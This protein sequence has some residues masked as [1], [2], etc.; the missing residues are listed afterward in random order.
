MKQILFFQ[1]GKIHYILFLNPNELPSSQ[2]YYDLMMADTNLNY[3][4]RKD[5]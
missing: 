3:S 5:I 4:R 1:K 2:L